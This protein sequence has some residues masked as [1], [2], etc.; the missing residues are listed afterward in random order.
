MLFH[1]TAKI[2]V[3]PTAKLLFN[4]TAKMLL[5]FAVWLNYYGSTHQLNCCGFTLQLN[6]CCVSLH[7][8]HCFTVNSWFFFFKFNLQLNYCFTIITLIHTLTILAHISWHFCCCCCCRQLRQSW[9]WRCSCALW[10]MWSP[11]RTFLPS[12]V[13]RSCKH[14]PASCSSSSTSFCRY[15]MPIACLLPL[16][17]VLRFTVVLLASQHP[18]PPF[19]L[20]L[21]TS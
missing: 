16:P 20:H 14:S 12:A 7:W 19:P 8:N 5:S 21:H 3:H 11:S 2:L 10:R 4:S 6:F 15:W 9:C 17:Y 13:V 1:S 18:S